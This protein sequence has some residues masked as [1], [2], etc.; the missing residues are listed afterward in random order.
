VSV[1][2]A[3]AF[4]GVCFAGSVVAQPE[5]VDPPSSDQPAGVVEPSDA[6]PVGPEPTSAGSMEVAAQLWAVIG[7]YRFAATADRVRVTLVQPGG[8]SDMHSLVVRCAPGAGGLVRL[9]LGDLTIVARQGGI[10][11]VHTQDSTTYAELPAPEDSVGPVSVLRG[12]LPPLAIPQLS[13]AFDPAVVDWCPLVSGL[14]WE[15]AERITIDGHDGVRLRG[16]TDVGGAMLDLAA[17]RVR[18][19]EADLDADGT[20]RLIVECEPLDP[21][22]PAGWVLDISDRRPVDRL[23]VL[24]PLGARV[25][26]GGRLPR[27]TLLTVGDP[28][29]RRLGVEPATGVVARTRLYAVLLMRD[30]MPTDD[31]RSFVASVLAGVVECRRELLRGRIDGRFAKTVRLVDFLGVVQAETSGGILERI[32][33]QAEAWSEAV[34]MVHA[35]EATKPVLTWYADESRLIDRLV[36]GAQSVL[37]VHD[38]GGTIRAVLAVDSL[39]SS[40]S[41]R[42]A[43][44]AAVP[45]V[46]PE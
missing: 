21:S 26:V 24:R 32:G 28:Q 34:A 16:R 33:S 39:T 12:L 29:E 27:A 8:R 40:E 31:T 9:E 4:A 43:M 41:V 2:L 37:V 46:L 17:A 6:V 38:G 5:V 18:R 3:I 30:D 23:E 25:E 44:V 10:R 1:R 20:T 35:A 22:D 45:V 11:A 14:S 36:P 15:T 13:L 42:D 7:R 19:F